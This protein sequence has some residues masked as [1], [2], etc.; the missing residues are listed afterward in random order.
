MMAVFS[1]SWGLTAPWVLLAGL[2]LPVLWWLLR[3]TPPAPRRQAFPPLSLLLSLRDKA[4]TA[5]RTPPWLLWLR[6]VI[7]GLLIVALAGPY[8]ERLPARPQATPLATQQPLLLLMDTGW[9]AGADWEQRREAALAIIAQAAQANRPLR[10]LS[11]ATEAHQPRPRLS[12]LLD[13]EAARATVMAQRPQAWPDDLLVTQKAVQDYRGETLWITAGLE[14]AGLAEL[15]ETLQKSGPLTLLTPPPGRGPVTLTV[16]D[17]GKSLTLRRSPATPNPE[18]A[19]G[20]RVIDSEGAVVATR[21]LVFSAGDD[22]LTSTLD[23]PADLQ[24]R[25]ARLEVTDPALGR[26]VDAAAVWLREAPWQHHSV[27]LIDSGQD[28]GLPLLS[29]V[30]YLQRA[31]ASVASLTL[32]PLDRVIGQP[33]QPVSARSEPSSLIVL[34][35]GPVTPSQREWLVAWVQA[36]GTLLRFAGDDMASGGLS[37]A[38]PLA[39][40][41]PDP[42]LPVTLRGAGRT[43]GGALSWDQP[44]SLAPFPSTSPFVGLSIPADVRV[45]RQVMA[46]P[47]PALDAHTW[48]RLVDGTPFITGARL[49]QGWVVL[50]HAPANAEWTNLPLSGLFPVLLERL[51]HLSVGRG[52]EAAPVP[53][54]PLQNLDGLGRLGDPLISAKPFLPPDSQPAHATGPSLPPGWY[55]YAHDRRAVNLLLTDDTLQIAA[56][57][58]GVVRSVYGGLDSPQRWEF[59]GVGLTGA[60]VLVLLDGLLS[61][62]LRGL[63]LVALLFLPFSQPPAKAQE[64]LMVQAAL[65]TRLAYVLTGDEALDAVTASGLYHLSEVV[66]ERTSAQLA[67]PVALDFSDPLDGPDPLAFFPL[68]YWPVVA[69]QAM[70]DE[71]TRERLLAYRR[72]GGTL[73]IDGRGRDNAEAL[74]VLLERLSIPA[75][76]PLPDDTVLA[77]SFYLLRGLPGRVEGGTVWLVGGQ[78]TA[79]HEPVSEQDSVSPLIIGANDWAGA[80]AL[81]DYGRPRLAM[82]SGGERGRE[83]ALRAGLNMVM[84]ALTGNY[85]ADQLHMKAIVER[86]G[87]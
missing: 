74:R 82:E 64:I 66:S 24:Q 42:L 31:L 53:L 33:S 49:G 58:P 54:P 65:N 36:G 30:W 61:L 6:L 8:A 15:Q 56:L 40:L 75:L 9:D 25:V 77:R 59:Q 78:S 21:T 83:L 28:S 23:L 81:D 4:A 76:V 85:K 12:G 55:G 1:L 22:R 20:L 13:A 16:A 44:A 69:G 2:G 50:L 45:R 7:A 39:P 72:H 67:A 11:T 18:Q 32:A 47:G 5:A 62:R 41:Q 26:P 80:W 73:V 27:T 84:V 86:L 71:R 3:V 46:E 37:A 10:F 57:P 79:H 51:V 68:I 14:R 63:L 70:P 52:G 48:A 17:D 29:Q 38:S 19:V 87:P 34:P 43:L 35:A 60:V